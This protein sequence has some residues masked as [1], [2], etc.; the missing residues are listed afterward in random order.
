MEETYDFDLT[1]KEG[2]EKVQ[3]KI[4][5]SLDR[6]NDDD[7]LFLSKLL[8][9]L[10]NTVA[11]QAIEIDKFYD[12]VDNIHMLKLLNNNSNNKE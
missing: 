6:F 12:I 7:K 9:L 5:E 1:T 8:Y 11:D 4:Q 3:K 2:K 10:L